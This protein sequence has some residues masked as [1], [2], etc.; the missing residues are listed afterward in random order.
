MEWSQGVEFQAGLLWCNTCG[1]AVGEDV[2]SIAY[3]TSPAPPPLS[4]LPVTLHPLYNPKQ[5]LQGFSGFKF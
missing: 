2:N 1:S 3:L 4:P 5:E